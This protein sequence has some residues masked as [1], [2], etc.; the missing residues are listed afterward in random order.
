M[1]PHLNATTDVPAADVVLLL[2]FDTGKPLRIWLGIQ[3]TQRYGHIAHRKPKK[4]EYF[5]LGRTLRPEAYG[6][7]F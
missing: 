5:R 3:F 2:R 1:H 4:I 7:L 6:N